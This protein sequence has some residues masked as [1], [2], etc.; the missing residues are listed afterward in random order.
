MQKMIVVRKD[1]DCQQAGGEQQKTVRLR[2]NVFRYT[3]LSD[4]EGAP[5]AFGSR[6]VG[7]SSLTE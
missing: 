7:T 6:L 1:G 3:N 4:Y 2:G 5:Q